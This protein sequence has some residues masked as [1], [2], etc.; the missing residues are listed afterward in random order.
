[1]RQHLRTARLDR[2]RR[3][4]EQAATVRSPRPTARDNYATAT[5]VT[6]LRG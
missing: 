1:M 5:L 3:R 4:F 6:G 2:R